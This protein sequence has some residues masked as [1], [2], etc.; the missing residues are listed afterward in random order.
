MIK[1]PTTYTIIK[2]QYNNKCM[3]LYFMY[4]IYNSILRQF[5]LIQLPLDS[6]KFIIR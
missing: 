2:M 5:H 4:F 6:I 1:T 3:K